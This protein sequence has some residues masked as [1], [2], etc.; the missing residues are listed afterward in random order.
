M[1]D[2]DSTFFELRRGS[3]RRL[4]FADG[5]VLT[6]LQGRIWLTCS[7]YSEDVFVDAGHTVQ[8]GPGAVIECDGAELARLRLARGEQTWG[9]L[10][11]QVLAACGRLLP[12]APALLPAPVDR[13]AV[14][15]G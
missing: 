13:K 5:R 12:R 7:G 2:S 11:A 3:A 8:L 15:G 4:D 14:D 6:V 10:A 1:K 9:Q